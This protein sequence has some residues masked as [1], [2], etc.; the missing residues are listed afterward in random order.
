[1]KLQHIL[2]LTTFVLFA[3]TVFS[4]EYQL[5]FFYNKAETIKGVKSIIFNAKEDSFR[6]DS[7][8]TLKNGFMLS[9][10]N[11][12]K[13][14]IQNLD[15]NKFNTIHFLVGYSNGNM[16]MLVDNNRNN[17]FSDDSVY[18]LNLSIKFYSINV[19]VNN[20]PLVYI[21]SIEYIDDHNKVQYYSTFFKFSPSPGGYGSFYSDSVQMIKSNKFNLSIYNSD[22]YTTNTFNYNGNKYYLEVT[23]NSLIQKVYPIQF[24]K[25][26]NASFIIG[27]VKGN[28]STSAAFNSVEN[29]LKN[30]KALAFDN[31]FLTI[32]NFNFEKKIISFTIDSVVKKNAELYNVLLTQKFS[33]VNT[34]K[35]ETIP[36]TKKEYTIIE[37]GGSWCLPCKLIIPQLIKLHSKLKNNVQLF[38]IAV[39]STKSIAEDYYKKNNFKWP[40]YFSELGCAH[41][42][43]L[44]KLF[45]VGVYPTILVL[46]KEGNIVFKDT[47]S[48][49]VKAVEKYIN[50]LNN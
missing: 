34:Q 29:L 50:N 13:K 21:D 33:I 23:P 36:F 44:T 17:N 15:Q 35:K 32:T 43:C 30:K 6:S 46:D 12:Y 16:I 41:Q 25:L 19:F 37:F 20:L 31:A 11:L 27:K 2:L 40:T 9:R 45:N 47:G 22:Y 8:I 3:S 38:S 26:S 42:N 18:V 28:D 39:E 7:V 4:Q 10:Y 48:D 49:A 24:S 14:S 1:M 5:A